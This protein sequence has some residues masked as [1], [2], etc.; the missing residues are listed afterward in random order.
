MWK[1]KLVWK[2]DSIE[3]TFQD[4]ILSL[5]ESIQ[6]DKMRFKASMKK[7]NQ[8]KEVELRMTLKTVPEENNLVK[9]EKQ[10][11]YE[12]EQKGSDK[13]E[14]DSNELT[15][16]HRIECEPEDTASSIRKD[17][18]EKVNVAVA[19]DD[20]KTPD[21]KKKRKKSD[22]EVD[23][24]TDGTPSGGATSTTALGNNSV[25]ITAITRKLAA[26]EAKLGVPPPP[27]VGVPLSPPVG[28]TQSPPVDVQHLPPPVGVPLSP[29]VGV[30][31]SLP[32]GV[33]HLPSPVGVPL[34]PHVG[35]HHLPPPVGVQQLPPPSGVPLSP[36]FGVTPPLKKV[37]KTVPGPVATQVTSAKVQMNSKFEVA[38]SPHSPHLTGSR[39][40]PSPGQGAIKRGPAQLSVPRTAGS[41]ASPVPGNKRPKGKVS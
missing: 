33:H 19:I 5:E 14:T 27:P 38:P 41:A 39:V 13:L 37:K 34:S 6:D 35:V 26:G 3:F 23:L 20:F 4:Q 36:P 29:P 10:E 15:D 22:S 2:N 28:G 18:E 16:S 40:M 12:Y 32:V 9:A 8:V 31:L 17:N 1:R 7:G 11:Y 24:Q 25:T 30:P 21:A